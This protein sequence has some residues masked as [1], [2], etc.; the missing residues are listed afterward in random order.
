MQIALCRSNTTRYL[1]SKSGL[2]FFNYVYNSKIVL[3]REVGKQKVKRNGKKEMWR[4]VIL[5][6]LYR[7]CK[8]PI[9][10]FIGPCSLMV[11]FWVR[12]MEGKERKLTVIFPFVGF[13]FFFFF[14]EDSPLSSS[15]LPSKETMKFS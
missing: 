14:Q 8:G 2:S 10:D 11:C 6:I 13:F 9:V 7:K 12:E 5:G 3:G 4:P 15:F 1:C